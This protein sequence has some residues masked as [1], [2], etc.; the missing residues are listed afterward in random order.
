MVAMTRT[1]T[2]LIAAATGLLATVGAAAAEDRPFSRHT[3]DPFPEKAVIMG[4]EEFALAAWQASGAQVLEENGLPGAYDPAPLIAMMAPQVELFTASG[5]AAERSEFVSIGRFAPAEA[6]ARLGRMDRGGEAD[7]TVLQR[8]GMQ[9]VRNT[10]RDLTL[11]PSDWLG[12]RHC[13]A[14]YGRLEHTNFVDLVRDTGFDASTWFIALPGSE[15]AVWGEQLPP[16][17]LVSLEDLGA[18]NA[19]LWAL[20]LPDGPTLPFRSP[21]FFGG[22]APYLTSHACFERA[23][24]GWRLAVVAVRLD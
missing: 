3:L 1:I 21:P 11:G 5:S 24:D 13:T 23:E 2:T 14:A 9:V 19:S 10:L 12:L 20:H 8:Y 15:P 22:L 6:L 4:R 7:A 17:L 18:R 16:Y